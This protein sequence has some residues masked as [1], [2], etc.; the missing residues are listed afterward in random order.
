MRTL[1]N[2][3]HTARRRAAVRARAAGRSRRSDEGSVTEMARALLR[4]A[5]EAGQGSAPARHGVRPLGAPLRPEA[6]L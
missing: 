2:N 5:R 6:R 1:A 4:E 3:D